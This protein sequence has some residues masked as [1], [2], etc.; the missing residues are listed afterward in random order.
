MA[1]PQ[2]IYLP[3]DV[4]PV[5]VSYGYGDTLSP[6]ELAAMQ[7]I[8]EL[9]S[10]RDLAHEDADNSDSAPGIGVKQVADLLGLGP[11]LT[12]DLIQDLFRRGYIVVD[13]GQGVIRLAPAVEQQAANGM[14]HR[15]PGVER[16]EDKV[17]VLY[18]RLTGHVL[19]FSAGTFTT[20]D[21][22]MRVPISRTE[23]AINSAPHSAIL[24]AVRKQFSYRNASTIGATETERPK[25]ILSARLSPAEL[26]RT[27][28]VRWLPIDVLVALDEQADRLRFTALGHTLPEA[29]RVK[30][31]QRLGELVVNDRKA[32]FSQAIWAGA[33]TVL[34]DP[35]PLEEN[36]K[37]FM[38]SAATASEARPG[39]RRQRHRDLRN[40]ATTI[41]NRIVGQVAREVQAE[42]V[43][44]AALVSEM[45]RLLTEAEQQ[46][47]LASPHIDAPELS[48]LLPDLR[49]ALERGVQL[50]L[51]WGTGHDSTLSQHARTILHDLS[52]GEENGQDSQ[53]LLWSGTPSR[54]DVSLAV[55]DDRSA[56]IVGHALLGRSAVTSAR[57]LGLLISKPPLTA[58]SPPLE[59]ILGWCARAMPDFRLSNAMLCQAA[60]FHHPDED[61]STGSD[62]M[63][64]PKE[65]SFDEAVE[66]ER[67]LSRLLPDK[68]PEEDAEASSMQVWADG[69]RAL[70]QRMRRSLEDRILPLAEQIENGAHRDLLWRALR[71]SKQRLMVASPGLRPEMVTPA[72]IKQLE[73][74]LREGLRVTLVCSP[75]APGAHHPT[76]QAIDELAR[77]YPKHLTLVTNRQNSARCL[78]S[79]HN[80]Y[81]GGYRFLAGDPRWHHRAEL[82]IWLR[83]GDDAERKRRADSVAGSLGA[84][85]TFQ[86]VG[87]DADDA[88]DSESPEVVEAASRLLEHTD[89]VG[90]DWN[91]ALAKVLSRLIER[92]ADPWRLPRYLRQVDAGK[93]ART[94]SARLLLTAPEVATAEANRERIQ[95][96]RD[97]W[98]EHRF[99]E[100]SI[101]RGS[102]VD[103]DV[104]P[105]SGVTRV[106]AARRTDRIAEAIES[107]VL[108]CEVE[109]NGGEAQL[110]AERT[111]AVAVGCAELLLVEHGTGCGDQIAEALRAVEHLPTPWEHLRTAVLKYW[112]EVRRPLPLELIADEIAWDERHHLALRKWNDLEKA[113]AAARQ[114]KMPKD[115]LLRMHTDLFSGD[116][117]F[118][119]LSPIL[120]HQEAAALQRWLDDPRLSDPGSLIDRITVEITPQG[121]LLEGRRRRTYVES[122]ETIVAVARGILASP[123][124]NRPPT[125]HLSTIARD[126]ARALTE[127]CTALESTLTGSGESEHWLASD[128]LAELTPLLS[129]DAS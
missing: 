53:R 46:F 102:V 129:W 21:P 127:H 111:A 125:S 116:G 57:K 97:L 35:P 13:F 47:V 8:A 81:V 67:E 42:V 112:N 23:K 29:L 7:I 32:R 6:I 86:E 10:T 107:L 54:L 3:C 44:A 118:G 128:A 74:R 126:V 93:V 115:H 123:V 85:K 38:Q 36:L 33:D 83:G 100:A 52:R 22:R 80:V 124:G 117:T 61:N 79:D 28:G 27:K 12:K 121:D 41:I 16:E 88:R 89:A 65:G 43:G 110:A 30:L 76:Y 98:A 113:L 109:G 58:W 2:V 94:V 108:E 18:E 71:D 78:V 91:D 1:R 90:R 19:P 75:A 66:L 20:H 62:T 50:V 31:E 11:R 87:H 72:L 84:N 25:K 103:A 40:E 4:V 49:Q 34:I 96:V 55:A 122:L 101:I 104:R 73:E 77:R 68:A 15:L 70:A 24:D 105:R 92:D 56:L 9:P 95:L 48:E 69:W 106:A 82:G 37:Q 60:D 51:L 99:I 17:D 45:R 39:T 5:H 14:L 59:D 119:Q 64:T 26:R 63:L 114:V 120:R